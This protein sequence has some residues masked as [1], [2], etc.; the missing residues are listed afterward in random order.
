ML[1]LWV[2]RFASFAL[3]SALLVSGSA[4]LA[5]GVV[6]SPR[7]IVVNPL[8]AYGV[9][10]WFDKDGGATGI[11]N[12]R[13]GESI[14]ISVRPS[15]DAYI[16]LYSIAAD[17]EVVQILPNRFDSAGAD[18]FVRGGSVR[19]F[20]PSDARYSYTVAPPTGLA[21]VIAV[22]S[23]SPLNVGSLATFRAGAQ[24][25]TSELGQDGFAFA[26]SIIVRPLPSRQ[27]VTGTALYTVGQPLASH[28]FGTLRVEGGAQVGEVYLDQSFIGYTP[29]S[30]DL[31]P[32]SYQVE[33]VAGGRSSIE[34]V[35]IAAGRTTTVQPTQVQRTGTIIVRGNVADAR[36]FVD[37]REVGRLDARD[38]Q[39]VVRDLPE[40][41]RQV[42]VVAPGYRVALSEVRVRAATSSFLDVVLMR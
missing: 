35:S 10:V 41:L 9:E 5:E 26:L 12:Y 18:N 33:V 23:Q 30:F 2:R 24:F 4:A 6:F 32:G 11:P 15:E 25:A 19:T 37:G 39:L 40:G 27:W 28:P 34:R 3:A 17:G 1:T 7:S 21:R 36:V 42:A 13:V 22:A 16:Y 38:L 31:R 29:L 14:R 8:P 20:P